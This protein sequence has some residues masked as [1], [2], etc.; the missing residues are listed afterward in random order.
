MTRPLFPAWV[1]ETRTAG[2]AAP[3]VQG[4]LQL[5]CNSDRHASFRGQLSRE[6]IG[7]TMTAMTRDLRAAA[8]RTDATVIGQRWAEALRRRYPADA[9]KTI[10]RD[11]GCEVRTARSW[12]AGQAPRA[13]A[14]AL[15][16][17]LHGPQ[18]VAE[19][20]MPEA[21][22]DAERRRIAQAIEDVGQTIDELRRR[23]GG[24]A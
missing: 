6:A 3:A 15:G 5:I 24:T 19:V 14:L 4:V 18:L 2:V 12:L 13:D 9:A 10:A 21:T 23:L 8:A 17:V 16:A 1:R 7:N 22:R 20:L 11:F